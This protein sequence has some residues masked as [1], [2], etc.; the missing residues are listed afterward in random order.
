MGYKVVTWKD[1]FSVLY[2]ERWR[3]EVRLL[4]FAVW[5]SCVPITAEIWG[6]S[7]E[8]ACRASEALP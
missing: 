4:C 8:V 3:P 5:G 2:V 7:L 1:R 6:Q